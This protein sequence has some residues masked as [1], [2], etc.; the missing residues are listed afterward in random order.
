MTESIR[1]L[2]VDDE[3]VVR[4][5]C[6]QALESCAA[7]VQT[8]G[9]GQRAIETMEQADVDVVLLDLMMPGMDGF[10]V[11]RWIREHRPATQV[12]VITGYAT[13]D[14]AVAAIKKGA[15]DFIGKPVTPDYLRIVV[16]RAIEKRSLLDE[17][18]R[19][20]EEKVQDFHLL[21]EE[22]SRLETVIKCMQGAVLVTD[23]QGVVVLQNPAAE[24]LLS[25]PMLKPPGKPVEQI[26]RNPE[27]VEM[28]RCA[29]NHLDT[30]SREFRPG[31]LSDYFLKACT[32]P[33]STLSGKLFGTVTVFEDITVQ[34]RIEQMKSE[35]VAMV[36]HELRSPLASIDQM[37]SSIQRGQDAERAERLLQRIRARVADLSSLISN[38]L[39]LSRLEAGTIVLAPRQLDCRQLVSGI[40]SAVS[41]RAADA[42]ISTVFTPGPYPVCV[43]ADEAQ[44]KVAISNVVDN[45][46]KYSKSGD[47]IHID[48]ARRG[49]RAVIRVSDQGLGIDADHLPRIFDRFYRVSDERTKGVTG[50]GLGLSLVKSIV[51]AHGGTV[52]AESTVNKGTTIQIDLPPAEAT[53]DRSPFPSPPPSAESAPQTAISADLGGCDDKVDGK[54]T[55]ETEPEEE[56]TSSH[57]V[58]V[59][60]PEGRTLLLRPLRSGDENQL[61]ALYYRLSSR[62][63]YLRFSTTVKRLNTAQLERLTRINAPDDLALAVISVPDPSD[64]LEPTQAATS[65]SSTSLEAPGVESD[66]RIIGV[67]RLY[68]IPGSALAEFSI[69]V[70]DQWQGRGVGAVLLVQLMKISKALGFGRIWGI[71]HPDNHRMIRLTRALGGQIMGSPTDSQ[72]EILLD[73]S[74]DHQ[75]N[76]RP[77]G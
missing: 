76:C 42:G 18:S 60:L 57:E 25:L 16:N 30:T 69:L 14:K 3:P 48:V 8:A 72:L 53:E 23:R 77:P 7:S 55:P 26:L 12:I 27:A 40:L 61:R 51:T 65:T 32:A 67:S 9:D 41:Q 44:L 10:E 17:A 38:L 50:S 4:A 39:D 62:S 47:E 1:I 36:S 70:E 33:V 46:I 20:R 54:G 6:A 45:A 74:R 52:S 5:G 35:F 73:C 2:V 11:L 28:V 43:K 64:F 59:T 68:G 37:I 66:H 56:P 29:V 24:T 22:R 58:S 19:L 71:V 21:L 34:K 13:I 49:R 15:F 63:L 75:H 31:A